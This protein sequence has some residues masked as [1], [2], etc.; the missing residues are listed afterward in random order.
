MGDVK[1]FN[2]HILWETLN[3]WGKAQ[4]IPIMVKIINIL[5]LPQKDLSIRTYH[6]NVDLSILVLVLQLSV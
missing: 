1:V 2:K 5:P 6:G 4:V 3:I